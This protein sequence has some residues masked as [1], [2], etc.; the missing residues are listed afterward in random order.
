V[1]TPQPLPGDT[2]QSR[3]LQVFDAHRGLLIGVAYRLL[4]SLADAEDIVQETWLRWASV[5]LRTV[6]NP[7]AFLVRIT[8]RLGLDRLRRIKA[9]REEYLGQWLPEPVLTAP[10]S[11]ADVE[12]A[13]S[14]SLAL[15]VVLETLSPLERAV[16]VLREAFDFSHAEVAEML[17]RTEVTV[18]QLAA[19]ARAHVQARKPRFET[20]RSVRTRV[21][22]RFLSACSTG[23][24]ANL[25][26][27]L[28]PG[29]TLI[30][31]G[32]G[33]QPSARKVVEGASAVSSFLMS[34]SRGATIARFLGL[35]QGQPLPSVR[36][37]VTDMNGGPGAVVYAG[38]RVLCALLLDIADDAVQVVFLISNPAKLRRLSS[39]DV[40]MQ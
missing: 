19:R 21:T 36:S 13:E 32:G 16:F 35:R 6:D 31:D 28:A 20:D 29:V 17:G 15:L 5:D 7:R 18:R 2:E 22:E 8:T 30:N 11:A 37:V 4:G 14:I 3:S 9:R 39:G 1:T 27:V 26:G 34:I 33:Q 23:D 25:L 38:E 12:W 24:V 10:D 40:H